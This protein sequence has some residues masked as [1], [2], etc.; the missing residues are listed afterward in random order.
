LHLEQRLDKSNRNRFSEF[1]K[2]VTPVRPGG[3]SALVKKAVFDAVEALM[4]EIPDR[5]PSMG[6]IAARAEVNPTSLYR[7]WGNVSILAT[8]VAID[9]AMRD[10]PIPDT[11]SLRGDL[12]GWADVIAQA[13]HIP[14]NL[15]L[16]RVLAASLQTNEPGQRERIVAIARRGEEL[17]IVLAR[18]KDRGESPPKLS[19]VL[20][21]VA[22]PIYFH[23]LF[24]G[25]VHEAGYAARLVDRLLTLAS[26][27][28]K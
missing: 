5:M 19:D 10:F 9:R 28:R 23:V 7:R 6:E 1:M 17:K 3:R 8:E 14:K 4:A 18:A 16:L 2:K 26:L 12:I 22:A 25:P 15:S 24:F 27:K 21:I 20:E 13:L 11:G